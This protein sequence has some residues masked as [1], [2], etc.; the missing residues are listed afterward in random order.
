MGELEVARGSGI[1]F[2]NEAVPRRY[3]MSAKM[4]RGRLDALPTPL[5][6]CIVAEAESLPVTR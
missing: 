6:T 2:S 5:L 3:P 4:R 1:L